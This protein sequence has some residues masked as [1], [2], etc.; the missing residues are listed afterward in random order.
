MYIYKCIFWE[1]GL[2]TF[3]SYKRQST[4]SEYYN[5][6]KKFLSGTSMVHFYINMC[7]Y[8]KP[9]VLYYKNDLYITK[10]LVLYVKSERI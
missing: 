2:L 1:G 6:E 9:K 8:L 10:V 7:R 5:L 3:Y 4:Y